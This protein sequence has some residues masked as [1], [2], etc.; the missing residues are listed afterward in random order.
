MKAAYIY[1]LQRTAEFLSMPLSNTGLPPH[2]SIAIDK[3]TPI[4]DTNEAIMLLLP[5]EGKRT[6]MPIDVPIVYGYSEDESSVVG[7]A[8]KDLADQVNDVLK[9][10][11]GLTTE[12]LGYL[13]GELKVN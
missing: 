2:F 13:R 8:G 6:A 4:R 9:R 1:S 7:G 5:F 10:K 3:S 11:L 12:Q